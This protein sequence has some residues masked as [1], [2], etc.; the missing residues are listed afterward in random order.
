MPAQNAAA[1]PAAAGEEANGN[2]KV[3]SIIRTIAIFVASQAGE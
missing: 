1:A 2:N 3:N